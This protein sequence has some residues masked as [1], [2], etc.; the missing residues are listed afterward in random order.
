MKDLCPG[1]PDKFPCFL[2]RKRAVNDEVQDKD[3]KKERKREAVA[4]A[5]IVSNSE[6]SDSNAPFIINK[7]LIQPDPGCMCDWPCLPFFDKVNK[8]Y[9][10]KG[11]VIVDQM[12]RN[13]IGMRSF[14]KDQRDPV[15]CMNFVETDEIFC[16]IK[17]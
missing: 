17:D 2:R 9:D 3:E 7:I 12:G 15:T 8:C 14:R 6:L 5:A 10:E 11:N 1:S 16:K 4:N 13:K